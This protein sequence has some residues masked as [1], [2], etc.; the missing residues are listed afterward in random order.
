[1]S[2]E[3][4]CAQAP[5]PGATEGEFKDL[6]G[7][8]HRI[9]VSMHDGLVQASSATHGELRR[10]LE[11]L[12]EQHAAGLALLEAAMREKG[13]E[14]AAK[15]DGPSPPPGLAS[16]RADVIVSECARDAESA[17]EAMED[18]LEKHAVAR[19]PPCVHELVRRVRGC[20]ANTITELRRLVPVA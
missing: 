5:E 18:A 17:A 3:K 14:R 16:L 15:G 11:E 4:S 6:L 2:H 8:V 13:V 7:R 10:V 1:M 12:A 19:M 9:F 20:V